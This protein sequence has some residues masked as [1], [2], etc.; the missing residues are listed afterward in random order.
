MTDITQADRDF[1]A[2]AAGIPFGLTHDLGVTDRLTAL[3]AIASLRARAER[4]EEALKVVKDYIDERK[5]YRSAKLIAAKIDAALQK[6]T[7][8]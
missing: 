5:V 1:L 2:Q 4:A 7:Q 8:I 6:D 3:R